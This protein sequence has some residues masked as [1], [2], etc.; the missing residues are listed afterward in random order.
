MMKD[1][2]LLTRCRLPVAEGCGSQ[3]E[4]HKQV[5]GALFKHVA[6]KVAAVAKITLISWLRS[7]ERVLLEG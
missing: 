3:T 1:A 4:P 7:H 5:M 2:T 6:A